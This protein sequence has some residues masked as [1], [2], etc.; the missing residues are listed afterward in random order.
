MKSIN[1][2]NFRDNLKKYLDEVNDDFEVLTVTRK[3]CRNVV[4]L[5]E[6]SYNNM[7]ENIYI[8]SQKANYDRII[9]A[10]SEIESGKGQ[11][12]NIGDIK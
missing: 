10:K 9:E 3:Q 5:S 8:R 11:Y 7:M 12:V 4:V 6:D 1:Y 2:S